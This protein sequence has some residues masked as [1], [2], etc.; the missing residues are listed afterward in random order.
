MWL[1]VYMY[2]MFFYFVLDTVTDSDSSETWGG[3]S[4]RGFTNILTTKVDFCGGIPPP[5]NGSNSNMKNVCATM[6]KVIF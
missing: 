5:K 6:I 4:K 2:N 1:E 3:S